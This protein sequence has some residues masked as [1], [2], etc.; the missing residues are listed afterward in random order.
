MAT[1]SQKQVTGWVGWVYFAGAMMLLLGGL[2]ALAGLIALF[3]NDFFVVTQEGLIALNFTAW[4]WIHIILGV[5]IFAAGIAVLAGNVW[6]RVIGVF[7]AVLSAI[8]NLGFITA[9]PLWSIVGLIIDGLVIYALTMH[10]AE[11]RD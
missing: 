4:G 3:N 6:G 2:Q 9:Y 8:A 7:L 10:G 11:A 1:N 5:I